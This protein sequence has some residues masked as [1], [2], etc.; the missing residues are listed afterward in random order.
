MFHLYFIYFSFI[1]MLH[2]SPSC[3]R[4][5]LWIAWKGIH[6]FS[7][8]QIHIFERF[9]IKM[10]SLEKM[11]KVFFFF[12]IDCKSSATLLKYDI[13]SLWLGCG[14]A[15]RTVT[16]VTYESHINPLLTTQRGSPVLMLFLPLQEIFQDLFLVDGARILQ[17]LGGKTG[18]WILDEK[19]QKW[20]D[21]Y[22][23]SSVTHSD[24]LYSF[25]DLYCLNASY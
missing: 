15:H 14:K 8:H 10:H 21:G 2:C 23:L 25:V 20:S 4:Q 6:P 3:S 17:S 24:E 19:R 9:P 13:M 22:F 16:Y 7:I 12:H 1:L 11:Y 18:A 5:L